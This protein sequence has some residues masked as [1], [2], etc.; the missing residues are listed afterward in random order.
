MSN[1]TKE[2]E[3]IWRE[4]RWIMELISV[5]RDKPSTTTMTTNQSQ[6]SSSSFFLSPSISL[7]MMPNTAST[8]TSRVIVFKELESFFDEIA[9]TNRVSPS[10]AHLHPPSF[11]PIISSTT[12]G[13]LLSPFRYKTE[14][15]FSS[16]TT[17]NNN[18]EFSNITRRLS[19]QVMSSTMMKSNN[20]NN[21]SWEKEFSNM[22]GG[23]YFEL[24][25]A[26]AYHKYFHCHHID[27]ISVDDEDLDINR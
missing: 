7:S 14:S 21:G 2:L 4:S 9:E 20:T 18:N 24:K 1:F 8:T 19:G 17:N 27:S 16:N 10:C 11:I 6:E 23:S 25:S 13:N 5:A 26:D 3:E 22:H 12:G 15:F